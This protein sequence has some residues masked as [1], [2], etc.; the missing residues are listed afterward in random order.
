MAQLK[1]VAGT[2]VYLWK[3]LPS[4]PAAITFMLLFTAVTSAHSWRMMKTQSWFCS[5]F[6]VGGLR[7]LYSTTL[8]YSILAAL[9]N[10]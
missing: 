4:L 9:R 7:T 8:L 10:S 2:D 3:Y 1:P 5:A 6:T